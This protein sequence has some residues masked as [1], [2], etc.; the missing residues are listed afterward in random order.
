MKKNVKNL[1]NVGC[2]TYRNVMRR[3]SSSACPASTRLVPWTLADPATRGGTA[4]GGV[5]GCCR[6]VKK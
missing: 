3:D 5:G 1:K 4:G 2:R 6:S